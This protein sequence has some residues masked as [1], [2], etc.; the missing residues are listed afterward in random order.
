[1][2]VPR[3][4]EMILLGD[5]LRTRKGWHFL[6]QESDGSYCGCALG[7]AALAIGKQEYSMTNPPWPWLLNEA[8]GGGLLCGEPLTYQDT[9]SLKFFSV[10]CGDITIEQLVDY[11]RSVELAEDVQIMDETPV[12]EEVLCT[13]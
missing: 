8:P 3:L 10:C 4:S 9:I 7:G 6:N 1:M 11:V 5:S 2:S 13:N 12:A